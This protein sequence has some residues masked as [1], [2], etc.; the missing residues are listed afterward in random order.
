MREI[1][2]G[3]IYEAIIDMMIEETESNMYKVKPFS[4]ESFVY[5]V[6][7]ADGK[8]KSCSCADFKW[9]AIAC[10]HIYLLKRKTTT[11]LY[12]KVSS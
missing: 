2:A 5:D 10:K 12:M 3:S 6:E 9:N 11:L 4:G 8:M 7:V 1:A